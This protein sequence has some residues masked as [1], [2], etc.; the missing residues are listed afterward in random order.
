MRYAPLL[1]LLALGC[2]ETPA[3]DADAQV[4]ASRPDLC[5]CVDGTPPPDVVDAGG[6]DVVDA[7]APVDAPDAPE[8]PDVV[9]AAVSVDAVDAGADDVP[10]LDVAGDAAAGDAGLD[11]VAVD[12]PDVQLAD[13]VDAATDRPDVVD[14]PRDA[15][16]VLYDLNAVRTGLEV[17]GLYRRTLSGGTVS[18]CTTPATMLSCAVM[19][20]TLRFAFQQ[21][22]VDFV[23]TFSVPPATATLALSIAIGGAGHFAASPRI[24]AGTLRSGTPSRQSFHIQYA[25]PVNGP[26]P[27]ATGIPG[28]TVDPMLGDVWLLGCPLN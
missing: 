10:G 9:D 5:V 24:E 17:V 26:A 14:V 23:G 6:V 21:C 20:D 18:D 16:P 11:A 25:R 3:P 19:G 15:G 8:L 1:A 2:S 4:D 12:A 22:G 27:G 28:R 13:V 7:P